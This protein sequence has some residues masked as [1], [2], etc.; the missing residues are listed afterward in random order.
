MQ[1]T[2]RRELE[3]IGY[4]DPDH[5]GDYLIVEH[6]TKRPDDLKG[7]SL[8]VDKL[9]PRELR[10]EHDGRSQKPPRRTFRFRIVVETEMIAGG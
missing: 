1:M 5:D 6:W 7:Q 3:G 10:T 9:L 8:S 4:H 2:D